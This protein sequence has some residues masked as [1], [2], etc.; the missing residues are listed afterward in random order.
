MRTEHAHAYW[1]TVVERE[2]HGEVHER[3]P[4]HE[5][6][7]GASFLDDSKRCH[8]INVVALQ[9]RL[10]GQWFLDRPWNPNLLNDRQILVRRRLSSL[11]NHLFNLLFVKRA[12]YEGNILGHSR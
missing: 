8:A 7:L 9:E 10:D 1:L 3:L 12:H 5:P 6:M 11:L 2:L 4:H